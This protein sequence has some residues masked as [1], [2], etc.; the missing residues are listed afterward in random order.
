[1]KKILTLDL[2]QQEAG[3]F[4][5]WATKIK[6]KDIYGITDGKAVGTYIEHGFQSYLGKKYC[7]SKGSSAKGID[8]PE[9]NIDI[10]V[11]SIKQPQSSCP[12]KS[13]R[14]K[15]YGLGYHLILFVYDKSDNRDTQLTSLEM[16]HT[17]FINKSKTA[18]FRLTSRILKTLD[19]GGNEEDIFADL[20]DSNLPLDEVESQNLAK[21][22]IK[23]P[24]KLG[25]LTLSNALQWRLQYKRIVE[26][27]GDI[28]G[29]NRL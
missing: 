20:A 24:P 21:E 7:Y 9:L 5:K 22:I 26:I 16:L 23:N 17:V 25:Y 8:L 11:T 12:F 19:L 28:E 2:I 13:A 1:M 14:Q 4:A 10:K 29:I 15:V 6:H 18:D 3:D 27:A